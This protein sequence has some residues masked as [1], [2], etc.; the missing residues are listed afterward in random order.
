[1]KFKEIF[2]YATVI[3]NKSITKNHCNL[4]KSNDVA[5]ILLSIKFNTDILETRKVAF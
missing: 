4:N 1:M 2:I 3:I 5:Q